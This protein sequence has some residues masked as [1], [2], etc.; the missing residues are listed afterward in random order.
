MAPKRRTVERAPSRPE[1]DDV[2]LTV[3]EAAE[4]AKV[5]RQTIYNWKWSGALP[6]SAVTHTAGGGLRI[7][8]SA[9]LASPTR[10]PRAGS[11]RPAPT[12]SMAFRGP[13]PANPPDLLGI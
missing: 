3:A 6:P 12:F 1:A 8:R 2:W 13:L 11:A 5:K 9:V 10:V 7:L 4:L